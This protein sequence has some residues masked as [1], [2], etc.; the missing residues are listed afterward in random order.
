MITVTRLDGRPFTLNADLIVS[1][2]SNPDTFI[3]LVNGDSFI[4]LESREE[5]VARVIAYRR[6]VFQ[7]AM[8]TAPED[9]P[10]STG[11]PT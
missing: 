6:Q 1:I 9:V 7:C 3:R 11:E 4:V 10:C 5:V 8:S 2:E